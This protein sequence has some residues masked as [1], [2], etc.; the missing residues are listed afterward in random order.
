[1]TMRTLTPPDTELIVT[2]RPASRRTRQLRKASEAYAFLSPTLILLF[3]LMIV[4][5]VM[6]IGYSFQDNVITNK[7]PQFVGL[8]N[9]IAVL[10]DAGFWKATGNT[11]FFTLT[12]VAAHLVLGLSFALLLN[13]RL[14]GAIPRAIF[15]GLYVL[16]WLFTVAVIAVLWRMLLAPNG[17][18]NFLLNTN[19][20]WLASPPSSPSA[21]SRSST[22]GPAT[23]SSW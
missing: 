18:V 15:R 9:Y 17:I 20:E 23:R 10:T 1:M 13:S 6:V 22:S 8:D 7:N 16:P 12:S 14:I 3:V 19:I 11:L 2:G 4:P 21:R 5:I